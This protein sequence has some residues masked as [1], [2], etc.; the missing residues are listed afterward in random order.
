[1]QFEL[2]DLLPEAVVVVSVSGRIEHRN[3]RADH[4]LGLRQDVVG[5]PFDD[6]V[7]LIDDSGGHC[8]GLIGLVNPVAPRLAERLLRVR[9]PDGRLRPVAVAGRL[10]G[11]RIVVTFRHGG[12]RERLDAARSDLVATVSHEIRSPL[13]SVKGF[14]RTLLLKWDRFS[15]EQK[16]TMLETINADADRVTRLL[17]EL[18][19]VSRIDANRVQLRTQRIDV[20]ELVTRIVERVKQRPEGD[21]RTVE[22]ALDRAMPPLL[23]DQDKIEQVI[24]NLVENALQYAP[25]SDVRLEGEANDGVLDLRVIDH[26]PGIPDDQQRRIFEKFGR[27]RQNR[28]AGTGLGLYISRG[29][30]RAHGGDVWCT[31]DEGTGA[32]FH[33]RLPF[34]PQSSGL[35]DGT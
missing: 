8:T 7:V 28:R 2:F 23:A 1:M 26:G 4:L 13:T 21:G 34:Q 15:D 22:V 27:G 3:D 16:H 14:T 9:L 31:S 30:A 19:D 29:L 32:T 12:R 17:T 25:D 33:L 10:H 35:S 11:A 18:L 5:Q 6:A 20:P 24:T